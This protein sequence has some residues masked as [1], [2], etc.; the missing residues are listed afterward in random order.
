MFVICLN[1]FLSGL[2][3]QFKDHVLVANL[4]HFKRISLVGRVVDFPS[5]FEAMRS[6][7]F[8]VLAGGCAADMPPIVQDDQV[9]L[10]DEE[11]NQVLQRLADQLQENLISNN[12]ESVED[13]ARNFLRHLSE[14][15]AA[16][17][18]RA[19]DEAAIQ[20]RA[21]RARITEQAEFVLVA[22]QHNDRMQRQAE[23][24]APIVVDEPDSQASIFSSARVEAGTPVSEQ[25]P[26][27]DPPAN[28]N[29]DPPA[30]DN[31]DGPHANDNPDPQVKEEPK[32]DTPDHANDNPDHPHATD[33]PG[34]QANEIS[35]VDAILQCPLTQVLESQ[36]MT[37]S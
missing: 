15:R 35:E 24:N 13:S 3:P 34:P 31:P 5:I 28:D 14:M 36:S 1:I 29:P 23:L 30:N 4:S 19:R 18:T 8:F 27:P 16:A 26:E 12:L 20:Q 10:N 22:V 6:L 2:S 37:H 21:V 7:F 33:D 25:E 11:Q 32:D 9:L 17:R